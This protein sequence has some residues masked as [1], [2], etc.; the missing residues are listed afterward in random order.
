[1]HYFHQWRE[2]NQD[3]ALQF[4][5]KSFKNGD[6]IQNACRAEILAA[7]LF[8]QCRHYQGKARERADAI[9]EI[10]TQAPYVHVL[11][12]YIQVYVYESRS[13]EGKAFKEMLQ[14]TGYL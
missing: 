6:V 7:I 10:L 4:C 13:E 3:R 5:I 1:M 2:W 12:N 11:Q 9:L 8:Q 14:V